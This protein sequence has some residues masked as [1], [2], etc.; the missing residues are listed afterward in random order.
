[1]DTHSFTISRIGRAVLER[2]HTHD[3]FA[4]VRE[5]K[6]RTKNPAVD[7][8]AKELIKEF[9][10][11]NLTNKHFYNFGDTFGDPVEIDSTPSHVTAQGPWCNQPDGTFEQDDAVRQQGGAA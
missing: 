2:P 6:P 9:H 7:L 8:A 5:S 4:S 1:M 11:T 3:H 10:M